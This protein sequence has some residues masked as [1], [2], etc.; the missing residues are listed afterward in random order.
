MKTMLID[1][2]KFKKA[3][4]NCTPFGYIVKYLLSSEVK[5][6]CGGC[7]V[8]FHATTSPCDACKRSF[9][10]MYKPAPVKKVIDPHRFCGTVIDM[11]FCYGK[12]WTKWNVGKL[13]KI[14]AGLYWSSVKTNQKPTKL[15]R[16]RQNH[17]MGWKQ[18]WDIVLPAGLFLRVYYS[19]NTAFEYT[20]QDTR[21]SWP[22][23]I[24]IEVLAVADGWRYEWEEEN[25][26]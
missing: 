3:I 12:D 24:G 19:N 20:S 22:D 1:V 15:C 2:E 26:Q 5:Q 8:T 21:I 10:D 9:P 6:N 14:S 18:G 13:L 11:E 7:A 17:Y 23:V 4:H 16:V 25:D